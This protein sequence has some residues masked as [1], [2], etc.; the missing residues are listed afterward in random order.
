MSWKRSLESLL[1]CAHVYPTISCA[2]IIAAG[3]SQEKALQHLEQLLDIA[4]LV[5]RHVE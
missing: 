5:V 3:G 1:V 4:G 2:G